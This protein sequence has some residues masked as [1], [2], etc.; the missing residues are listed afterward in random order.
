MSNVYNPSSGPHAGGY[1]SPG[2]L[3]GVTVIGGL[4]PLPFQ[5]QATIETQAPFHLAWAALYSP[6][7]ER[8][9][10]ILRATENGEQAGI[11][12]KCD[13]SFLLKNHL[14]SELQ[15]ERMLRVQGSKSAGSVRDRAG[16]LKEAGVAEQWFTC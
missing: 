15:L 1:L 12:T 8:K 3:P 7:G 6:T 4:G 2:S 10:V 16:F 9:Q 14:K 13:V 5:T 11:L